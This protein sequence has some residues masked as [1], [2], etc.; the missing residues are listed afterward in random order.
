MKV[1]S[2]LEVQGMAFLGLGF[3]RESGV[4]TGTLPNRND[5]AESS[6]SMHQC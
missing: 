2:L 1:G 4:L 5:G 6:A 3:F